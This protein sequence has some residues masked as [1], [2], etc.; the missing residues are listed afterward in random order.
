MILSVWS[1]PERGAALIICLMLMTLLAG[2]G[3]ALIFVVD[4]ETAISA[5]HRVAQEVRYGA[6][7]G[8]ECGIAELRAAALWTPITGA[9]VVVTGCLAAA[10]PARTYD[11]VLIDVGGLT[12]R[13]QAESD[14]RYGTTASNPDAPQW[15]LLA[16]G[17]AAPA[18]VGANV[19]VSAYVVLWVADDIGDGDADPMSDANGVVVLRAEAFGPRGARA[20]VEAVIARAPADAAEAGGAAPLSGVR[21]I[22]W[23]DV[24]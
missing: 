21:V 12:A 8:L 2:L 18:G 19:A 5:N 23:R 20:A 4:V 6:E 14:R 17:R 11:G 3:G 1:R 22:A 7:A 13:L 9:P 16:H 10:V 24:R 15:R